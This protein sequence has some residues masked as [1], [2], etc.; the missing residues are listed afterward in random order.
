MHLFPERQREMKWYAMHTEPLFETNAF[1]FFF[2]YI[3][4]LLKEAPKLLRFE[5]ESRPRLAYDSDERLKTGFVS[6]F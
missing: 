2:L 6:Y 3:Q 5:I 4:A 1:F